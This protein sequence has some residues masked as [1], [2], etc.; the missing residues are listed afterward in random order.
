MRHRLVRGRRPLL[1][2]VGAGAT[3]AALALGMG[4][5]AF[6]ATVF[7][8]NFDDG[9]ASGWSKSGGDWAVSGG[10]FTQ[11]NTG[12]ELA[13]Q[14]A[15]QTAWTDYQVQARV[16]PTAF[17]SSS[18]LVGLAARSSSNT[19]MY[20]LAL[21]GSGRAELQAV[22]GSQ[23]TAIGSASIGISTG[24]WY[25][26]RIEASGSTIRGFVNGSQIASGSNSLVSAG[27]IGL[28]TSYAS[29]GFDDVTVD[30][31]GGTTPPSTTAP[32]APTTAPPSNPP[33]AGNWPTP[34][35]SQK[36]DATIPVSG[37]FDGGM[38]RYYGIGDGGQGESQDPMFVL[39]AGATLRNVIIGAPAGDGVHC[40]GNC[41]LTNVWWE[42]V[43][44]DAATFRG[45]S[46]YTVDGGGAR[47]GSDKVFQHNGGGTVYIRNFRV[48]SSGK[49]YR[50]CGNCST[51]YQRHVVM[52]NV[53]ATS[54]KVLAGINTNWGDTARFSRI[55]IL[56]DAS[57][58]T[59]ICEKYRGVP[60]GSEP[61]KI[62]EGADGVNC[63]YSSSD[64]T[65]R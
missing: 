59:V 10:A 6:A 53:T 37:S 39:A 44:E 5:S 12:S 57:R 34:T 1:L 60:K 23:V 49:L 4:T 55:T 38:R 26:L 21:L 28:I 9:D 42:D 2:A 17:G 27:R 64:I 52:D 50:A 36:V 62:G 58:K 15:G 40:E 30:S 46:T 11:S 16:R 7:T 41:T 14:F 32:P 43:G 33:P 22:N 8:D 61:T 47:S 51:S 13:R 45:G 18:A 25:T 20:R 19:K 63:I 3:V 31:G 65:Y 29:G 56:N 35:S 24:T 48:E 54:T